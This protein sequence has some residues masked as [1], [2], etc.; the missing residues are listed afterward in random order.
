LDEAGMFKDCFE[1]FE[2]LIKEEKNL[3]DAQDP[4][5]NIQLN[6][7]KININAP[8]ESEAISNHSYSMMHSH[9][10]SGKDGKRN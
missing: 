7:K 8:I 9:R 5:A 6:S 2:K 10:A 4:S 1:H 3:I